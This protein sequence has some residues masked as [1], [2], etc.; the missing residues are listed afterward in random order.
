MSPVVSCWFVDAVR[1]AIENYT[2]FANYG[3]TTIYVGTARMIGE[4]YIQLYCLRDKKRAW[5]FHP[6]SLL[7][8]VRCVTLGVHSV[9][10]YLVCVFAICLP[11]SYSSLTCQQCL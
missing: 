7:V 9:H 4:T 10:P 6:G 2:Y 5:S 1:G 11:Y 8:V 3:D